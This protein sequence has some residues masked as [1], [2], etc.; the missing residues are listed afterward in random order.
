MDV[1][2]MILIKH[3]FHFQIKTFFIFKSNLLFFNKNIIFLI[4]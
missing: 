2:N 1:L 3:Y 4:Y